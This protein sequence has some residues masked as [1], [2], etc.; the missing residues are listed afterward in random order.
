[1]KWISVFVLCL[2]VLA[3]DV[4]FYQPGGLGPVPVVV[5]GKVIPTKI[6]RNRR[7]TIQLANGRHFLRIGNLDGHLDLAT[8]ID[9]TGKH[10]VRMGPMGCVEVSPEDPKVIEE[11]ASTKE[12][13]PRDYE[14]IH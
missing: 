1:M 14:S 3:G 2:P 11:M 5:D 4:T 10:L 13:T 9:V 8:T 12:A 7:I 6:S